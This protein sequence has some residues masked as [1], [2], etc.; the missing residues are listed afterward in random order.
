[1]KCVKGFTLIEMILIIL[2]LGV[3]IPPMLVAFA[4]LQERQ[5]DQNPVLIATYLTQQQLEQAVIRKTFAQV[6]SQ[7]LTAFAAPFD[8]YRYQT[9][10]SYVAQNNLD[11]SVDP[12]VTNFKRVE[13]IVTNTTIPTLNVRLVTLV[14]N[15]GS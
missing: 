14:T 3:S 1:M 10:V 8:T 6:A 7:G 2:I 9:N 13:V 12:T 11:V 4:S 15:V 5:A